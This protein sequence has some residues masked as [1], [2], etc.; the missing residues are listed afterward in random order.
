MSVAVAG[1]PVSP[2]IV[3]AAVPNPPMDFTLQVSN[4]GSASAS[5]VVLTSPLPPQI[6]L[7]AARSTPGV[8]LVNGVVTNNVGALGSGQRVTV[9]IA[10]DYVP[11]SGITISNSFSASASTDTRDPNTL[12]NNVSDGVSMQLPLIIHVTNESE[13]RAAVVQT[14]SVLGGQPR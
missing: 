2:V 13:L 12:N 8:S 5:G 9:V 1:A 7:N 4:A 10:G 11:G 3:T 6:T 14:N